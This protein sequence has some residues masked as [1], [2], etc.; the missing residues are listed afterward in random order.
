MTGNDLADRIAARA[1]WVVAAFSLIVLILILGMVG[2]GVLI[3]QS[4]G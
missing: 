1:K 4:L 3:G 2:C